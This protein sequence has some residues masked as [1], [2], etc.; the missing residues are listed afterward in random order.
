MSPRYAIIVPVHGHS[1]LVNDAL[2]SIAALEDPDAVLTILINDGCPD[3]AT[4]RALTGWAAAAP[5]RAILAHHVNLGLSAARN[6]GI[7]LA[8]AH[9]GIDAVFFLDA[10]N[11]LDPHSVAVWDQHMTSHQQADWFYPQFD[12]FGTDSS[13]PTMAAPSPLP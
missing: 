10:D 1:V 5:E 7:R 13:P 9:E 4:A 2:A 3:P 11:R 12:F 6:T 8:L